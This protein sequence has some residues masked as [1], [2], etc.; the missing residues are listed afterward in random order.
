[1][2]SQVLACDATLG[3]EE[4]NNIRVKTFNGVDVRNLRHLAEMVYRCEERF[5]RFD[6]EYDVRVCVDQ[7][8]IFAVCLC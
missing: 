1:M 3:Y 7:Q 6:L 2:L 5:L 4:L 8:R